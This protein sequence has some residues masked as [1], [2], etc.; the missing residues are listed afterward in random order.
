[1]LATLGVLLVSVIMIAAM[2]SYLP[3]S[4]ANSIGVPI[5]FYPLLWLLLFLWAMFDVKLWRVSVGLLFLGLAH[6]AVIAHGLGMI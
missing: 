1:M 5:I 6:T 4:Q 3:F 2:P